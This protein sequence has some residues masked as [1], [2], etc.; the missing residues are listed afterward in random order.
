[1]SNPRLFHGVFGGAS[2][3]KCRLLGAVIPVDREQQ[4][5]QEQQHCPP[6][7]VLRHCTSPR[8]CRTAPLFSVSQGRTAKVACVYTATVLRA[9]LVSRALKRQRATVEIRISQVVSCPREQ[10]RIK[11][12]VAC[13]AK[14]CTL[15]RWLI[16]SC[17]IVEMIDFVHQCDAIKALWVLIW[18]ELLHTK[19]NFLHYHICHLRIIYFPTSSVTWRA[20][21]TL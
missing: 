2:W 15:E 6:A 12:I 10:S 8:R 19:C 18:D 7:P 9:D 4:E 11:L 1:M 20:C 3:R 21:N 14:R 5:Q 16:K 13:F 17:S